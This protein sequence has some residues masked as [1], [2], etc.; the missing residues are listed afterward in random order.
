MY[1]NPQFGS[2]N[3]LDCAG[4]SPLVVVRG[5]R[6][7]ENQA[8]LGYSEDG[9]RTWQPMKIPAGV[10][11]PSGD[12]H[13]A[14]TVSADGSTFMVSTPIPVFSRDRGKSWNEVRGLFQGARPVAD[15][16]DPSAF[17]AIN[18]NNGRIF[19]SSDG[20]ATFSGSAMKGLPAD[21]RGDE[22]TWHEG[23]WPLAATP[24]K[25]HDLWFISGGALYHSDDGGKDF[26]KADGS[27]DV[28]FIS[29]GKAAKG[30]DYPAIFVVA[31]LRGSGRNQG[32]LAV[33]R[34]GRVMGSRE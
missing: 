21:I 25:S 10:T 28:Q 14:I 32:D 26:A 22:P 23:P 20:G 15:R 29:F 4:Q 8:S 7:N 16:V 34:H 13:P 9:G 5:G 30:K 18:F 17:Y 6:P 12:E 2:T 1:E 27:L 19:I 31:S 33:R 11:R 24:G 3:S